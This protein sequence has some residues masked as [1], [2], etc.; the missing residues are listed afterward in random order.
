MISV[1]AEDTVVAA[2]LYEMLLPYRH[3]HNM[4]VAMAPY[5]G[6]VS[7]TLGRL[8]N[9]LGRRTAARGH[10]S[11]AR[12]QSEGMHAP[13]YSLA[14]RDAIIALGGDDPRLT[15][16]EAQVA[17]LVT[18]GLTNREI[19]GLLFLSERT[20]ENHVSSIL[21]RLDVPNRAAAAALLSPAR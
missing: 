2:R 1:L 21:R 9:F 17:E 13:W 18:E 11:D 4:T 10:F 7:L 6:P 19:A 20:V 8:A 16:R 5:R 3:Q 12:V 15:P 14:A